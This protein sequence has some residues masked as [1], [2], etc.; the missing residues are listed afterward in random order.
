M[1]ESFIGIIFDELFPEGGDA[2][3]WAE[4][5]SDVLVVVEL[6]IHVFVSAVV[7][8][9]LDLGSVL[10]CDV[11]VVVETSG[12]AGVPEFLQS[13]DVQMGFE[14]GNQDE[15]CIFLIQLQ[16][17]DLCQIEDYLS[18]LLCLFLYLGTG[19]LI[20]SFQI[21]DWLYVAGYKSEP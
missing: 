8:G 19:Q 1:E 4:H 17:M 20:G 9:F 18:I 15:S 6:E 14:V 3:D 12:A 10:D 11:E 13:L 16:K 7:E 5:V 21:E 2:V